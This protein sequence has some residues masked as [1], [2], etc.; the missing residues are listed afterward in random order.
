MLFRSN[1]DS[2][3][4]IRYWKDSSSDNKWRWIY[5]D[6]DLGC[7]GNFHRQNFLKERISP[8]QTDWY[9]PTWTTNLLRYTT[10]NPELRNRFVQQACLLM[11]TVLQ[12]D[13]VVNRIDQFANAIASEIPYHVNRFPITQKETEKDWN[14]HVKNYR[15]F[16]E[17]RPVS[18]FRHVKEAYGLGD[19]VHL[20]FTTNIPDKKLLI[21]NESKLH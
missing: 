7:A 11:C 18:M 16:W 19:S 4:N 13:T 3:G 8:V 5:Y 2:R 10:T 6:G 14:N 12:K 1:V 17:I 20:K 9:N 15:K 21:V